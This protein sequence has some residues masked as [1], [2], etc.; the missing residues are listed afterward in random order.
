MKNYQAV[1]KIIS[2][3][4]ATMMLLLSLSGCGKN[5]DTTKKPPKEEII[6]SEVDEPD[7]TSSEEETVLPTVDV[8]EDYNEG[9]GYYGEITEIH[10]SEYGAI[11]NDGKDDGEAIRRAIKKAGS[12]D[13]LVTVIFDNGVYNISSKEGSVEEGYFFAIYGSKLS[14]VALKGNGATLMIDDP[15]LSCFTFKSC[16]GELSIDGFNIDYSVDP[17][18]QGEVVAFDKNAGTIDFKVN[19]LRNGVSILDHKDCWSILPK[20]NETTIFGMIKDDNDPLL[21]KAGTTNYFYGMQT[22][23]KLSEGLYRIQFSSEYGSSTINTFGN[24]IVVGSKLVL[25]ARI[26]NTGVFS[27]SDHD[28]DITVTNCNVYAS[29][30]TISCIGGIDGDVTYDNVKVLATKGRWTTSNADGFYSGGIRGKLTITNCEW[31]GI[32]DDY[33]NLYTLGYDIVA[34]SD[35]D[36]TINCTQRTVPEIG[37]VVTIMDP[38]NGKIRGEATITYVQQI[39]PEASSGTFV[40]VRVILDRSIKLVKANSDIMIN[41][42]WQASGTKIENNIFRYA[43]NKGLKFNS[44]NT[45]VRGNKFEHVPLEAITIHDYNYQFS[46]HGYVDK[47]IIENNTFINCAYLKDRN[48]DSCAAISIFGTKTDGGEARGYVHSNIKILNNTITNVYRNAIYI[49][50]AAK[51]TISGN[52]IT[53]L[54][55]DG[56]YGTSGITLNIVKQAKITGNTFTDPRNINAAIFVQAKAGKNITY[57]DNAF[58]LADGVA[59]VDDRRSESNR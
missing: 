4:L 16:E 58:N 29:I 40:D 36:M 9:D 21:F 50:N 14:N 8:D 55:T 53:G 7:D 39:S 46:E 6:V 54:A 43:R 35:S 2:L 45:L 44:I 25:N 51:V 11:P 33:L 28:G 37:D 38:V 52:K 23:T 1:Q 26:N 49:S 48:V 18:A 34:T 3:C 57:T 10:V 17:W 47:C 30:G 19:N 31:E 32:S 24:K 41:Q 5:E 59:T 27:I 20:R 42:E 56:E 13:T 12:S 22:A 15:V